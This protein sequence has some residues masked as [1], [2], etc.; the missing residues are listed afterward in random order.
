[1]AGAADTIRQIGLADSFKKKYPNAPV[2]RS[3][4]GPRT[5][6]EQIFLRLEEHGHAAIVNECRSLVRLS[7]STIHGPVLRSCSYTIVRAT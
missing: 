2:S 3:R 4:M 1:V 6:K 5:Y 7:S